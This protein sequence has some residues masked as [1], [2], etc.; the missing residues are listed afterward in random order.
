MFR[1]NT[2]GS[3]IIFI[4]SY[5]PL[6]IIIVIQNYNSEYYLPV[7]ES[8]KQ[9]LTAFYN[10]FKYMVHSP[11]LAVSFILIPLI[12][13]I[14]TFFTLS[15]INKM[16]NIEIEI[17]DICNMQ[18]DIVNYSIPYFAAFF[19]LDLTDTPQIIAFFTFLLTMFLIQNKSEY[20]FYNPI[21]LLLGYKYVSINYIDNKCITHCNAFIKS[22]IEKESIVNSCVFSNILFITSTKREKND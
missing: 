17:K 9:W 16:A 22:N 1:L 4:A 15:R 21:I 20:I 6:S 10:S 14:L 13:L 19:Q 3:L 5:L 11:T 8:P 7:F 12:C 2:L 18:S